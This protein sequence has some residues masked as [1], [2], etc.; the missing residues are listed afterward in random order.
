MKFVISLRAALVFINLLKLQLISPHF[1]NSFAHRFKKYNFI[2]KM[3]RYEN[4]LASF[5]FLRCSSFGFTAYRLWLK[6]E[7]GKNTYI[8]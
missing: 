4:C 1:Y 7:F 8:I 3:V 6:F 2:I 5:V